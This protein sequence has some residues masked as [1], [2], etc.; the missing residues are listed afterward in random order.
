MLYPS[1]IIFILTHLCQLEFFS[2]PM[3]IT[4]PRSVRGKLSYIQQALPTA[5]EYTTFILPCVWIFKPLHVVVMRRS[6]LAGLV[7]IEK[8]VLRAVEYPLCKCKLSRRG[9]IVEHKESQVATDCIS[10]LVKF[11]KVKIDE[12]I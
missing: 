12:R 11:G 10:E 7:K 9:V 2:C 8:E 3:F 5:L 6:S 4:L 1:F